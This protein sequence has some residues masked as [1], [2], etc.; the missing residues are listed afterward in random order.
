MREYGAPG[1]AAGTSI[2]LLVAAAYLVFLFHRDYLGD[3]AAKL[4][5]DV[6]LRPWVAGLSATAVIWA[7]HGAV[8][9]VVEL[10]Q[11]RLLIPVKIAIDFFVFAPAYVLLLVGLRHVTAID[12]RN[13][14]GLMSFGF[15]FVR[16]PLRERVKIYR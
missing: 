15:E 5:R 4:I 13:L 1:A 8:P 9:A 12:W 7:F 6:H 10:G 14:T 3:S 2:A 11:P 16:H